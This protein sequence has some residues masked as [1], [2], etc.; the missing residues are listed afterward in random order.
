M[1]VYNKAILKV[2]STN[3]QS[4]VRSAAFNHSAEELDDT[5]MGDTSRT[6]AAGL[7][8]VS[9]E[10]EMNQSFGSTGPDSVFATLVGPG[11]SASAV[12]WPDATATSTPSASAPKYSGTAVIT[13]YVPVSGNVGD[14]QVCTVSIVNGNTWTRA[15]TT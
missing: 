2:G 5:V 9:I 6:S 3:L 11:K 13:E 12:F 10:V 15:I 8:R 1:A 14:Q 7:D 4:Y